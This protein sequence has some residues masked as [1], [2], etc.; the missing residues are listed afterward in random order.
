MG[1]EYLDDRAQLIELIGKGSQ[2]SVF[3]AQDNFNGQK[4][5]AK[6]FKKEERQELELDV[7]EKLNSMNEL[8][9]PKLYYHGLFKNIPVIMMEKL[10]KS[11]KR[12]KTENGG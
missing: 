12:V 3:S 6:F 1:P 4:M 5:A 8:G 2:G 11:L 10:G 9:F 7:L